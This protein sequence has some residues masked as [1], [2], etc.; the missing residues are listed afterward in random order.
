MDMG[1]QF[2]DLCFQMFAVCLAAGDGWAD[3]VLGG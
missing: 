1:G 2:G 3:C